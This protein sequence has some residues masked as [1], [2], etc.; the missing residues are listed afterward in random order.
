MKSQISKI[1]S[2]IFLFGTIIAFSLSI[3][4]YSAVNLENL[5]SA[6]LGTEQEEEEIVTQQFVEEPVEL[7][8]ITEIENEYIETFF[9]F[10]SSPVEFLEEVLPQSSPDPDREYADVVETFISGGT[11]YDNFFINDTSESDVDILE[12]LEADLPFTADTSS[13]EPLVLLYHTHTS[14]SYMTGFTGYYYTDSSHRNTDPDEN[15][16]LVGNAIAEELEAAGISV[17]HDTTIHDSPEYNGAYTRSMETV[18][19]YL[20]EYPS[21]IITIDIHRDSMTTDSGTK[22]KPTVTID[23]RDAAQVMIL[24]GSDPTGELGFANWENNLIF[25]LKI[26]QLASELYPGLLR[27]LMFCQRKY[28]MDVAQAS[29]LIEVGTEV[30]TFA[31]AT[32]SGE[33]IGDVIAQIINSA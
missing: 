23:G 30:N 15:V 5:L 12:M 19:S 7:V 3:G 14:E 20:D 11:S 21:I 13:G 8:E 26:Q 22:Y 24:A 2:K 9:E 29:L 4:T 25:D 1:L 31:E 32:Y 33:L 28:N 17:I 18:Q 10:P 27:P 6:T 16:V